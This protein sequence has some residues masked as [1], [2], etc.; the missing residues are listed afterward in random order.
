MTAAA[1]FATLLAALAVVTAAGG[2][3]LE[4]Q[5]KS[6]P[7]GLTPIGVYHAGVPADEGGAEIAG[8]DAR[9]R[10]LFVVN[11]FQQRID[12]IDLS[13]PSAP[14]LATV[15]DVTPYGDQANSVAV[16]DGIVA[17][18][19]QAH[20]KT[21][22]GTVVFFTAF[23]EPMSAVTVG[24]LPDMLTFTPN[25]RQ[26]L[27]ANEGEPND[28]YDVDPEGSISIIAMPDDVRELTDADV[29]TAGFAAFNDVPLD[30][31]IRIFGPGATVAQDLEPEYIAVSHDSKTA[32]VTLQEANAL[33][34]LDLKAKKV[35]KLV[36]LGAKNHLLAGNGLD[37]SNADGAINIRPW[38]VWGLYLPDA[39]ATFH[40]KGETFLVTANEGDV[41]EYSGFNAAGTEST[42]VEDLVLD[43]T[44]FPDAA[45][46]QQ[47]D[48]LGNLKVT[49]SMGDP[50]HDG[51]FDQ[52]FAFGARSFSIW[53]AAGAKVFDSGDALE[54]ITA[55]AFPTRFNASNTNNTFDNR[56]DDKGPEPEGLTVAK[57]FGRTFVFIALERI[58][59]IVVYEIVDPTA[60]TFVQYI[61]V[62]D[63]SVSTSAPGAGDLG[64]EGLFV[65]DAADSPNGK[66]L[67]V[68]ANEVSG[69]TRI[70]EIAQ[71]R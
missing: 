33:A 46:L 40:Q 7:I 21:D 71:A 36:A 10:R 30:P 13:T 55:A 5:P 37:A 8:Y 4:G 53:N 41:R 1:R 29:T 45:L 57:L 43:P 60:P 48:Q 20:V 23:G 2:R 31:M 65:I 34:I 15:I 12:V 9:T 44:A 25:G 19:V 69:T 28:D 26:V 16:H 18:A 35:T 38:P 3:P 22:P 42:D 66:P 50:D 58:G 59:G 63:F 56:S 62:R 17:I 47:D 6:K 70:Y 24:A 39:I 14:A 27:V 51:D 61:N 49:V 52:L 11:L 68:V 54:R 32:W 67:L 64:P